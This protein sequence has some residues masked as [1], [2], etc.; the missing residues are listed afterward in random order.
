[1]IEILCFQK[2]SVLVINN[3]DR[4]IK[5]CEEL[6]NQDLIVSIADSELC[7]THDFN[8]RELTVNPPYT[9]LLSIDFQ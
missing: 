9:M 7:T 3:M 6:P 2:K 4:Q 5:S 1:M 8:R